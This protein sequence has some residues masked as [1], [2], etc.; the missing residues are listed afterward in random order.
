LIHGRLA[1]DKLV[2]DIGMFQI[3]LDLENI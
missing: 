1:H 3:N 2:M